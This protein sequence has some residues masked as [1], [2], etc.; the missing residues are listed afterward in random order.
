MYLLLVCCDSFSS[1]VAGS[2][3]RLRVAVLGLEKGLHWDFGS[4]E[5]AWKKHAMLGSPVQPHCGS[6][7]DLRNGWRLGSGSRMWCL[8]NRGYYAQLLVSVRRA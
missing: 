1:L 7:R 2:L 8:P 3:I 4:Y 6:T 5:Y